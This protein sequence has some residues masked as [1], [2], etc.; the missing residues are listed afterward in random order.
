MVRLSALP[1]PRDDGLVRLTKQE[2]AELARLR[3]LKNRAYRGT[4]LGLLAGRY[5]RWKK[6]EWGATEATMVGY[7]AVVADLCQR[8]GERAVTDLEPPAGTQFVREVMDD[9]YGHLSPGTR[10]KATSILKDFFRFLV[11]DAQVLHGDPTLPIRRPKKR[12]SD[13]K[14]FSLNEIKLIILASRGAAYPDKAAVE[15]LFVLAI[16]KGALR[17]MQ[18]AD[19]DAETRTLKIRTKGENRQVLPVPAY[20]AAVL[21]DHWAH[22]VDHN[23]KTWRSEYLLFHEHSVPTNRADGSVLDM[24]DRMR[25]KSDAALHAWWQRRVLA[26]FI[27]YR[28][29]HS[30]RHTRLTQ[31]TRSSKGGLKQAQ[32]L[33]GHKS[34]TTTGDIYA[35]LDIGDLEETLSALGVD[36]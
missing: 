3:G 13:R 23:P 19:Y 16:R 24:G 26:A 7:E 22:R 32:L 28:S 20:L 27:P 33:A 10:R 17:Q 29:M 1:N 12:D 25:P 35:R 15:T 8:W 31:V 21:D 34:I 4:P 9:R 2:A 18:L 14:L 11:L 6:N 30:V 36:E 5:I